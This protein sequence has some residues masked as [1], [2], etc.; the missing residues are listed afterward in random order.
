MQLN[1]LIEQATERAGG[2]AVLGTLLA[3][4]VSQLIT[5]VDDP[6]YDWQIV[7]LTEVKQAVETKD[8]HGQVWRTVPD[9]ITCREFEAPIRQCALA[10]GHRMAQGASEPT[11]LAM[12]VWA[13]KDANGRVVPKVGAMFSFAQRGPNAN[14]WFYRG[15]S[16][17][18]DPR[19]VD[20]VLAYLNDMTS[21]TATVSDLQGVDLD[22]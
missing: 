9:V 17:E 20:A 6:L 18:C 21:P 22:E 8:G 14:R 5:P 1:D 16:N 12:L 10:W 11:P 13:T 4:I 2:N 3:G 19:V 15:E 7:K